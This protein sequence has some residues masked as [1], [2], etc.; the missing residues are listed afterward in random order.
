MN[1]YISSAL[2]AGITLLIFSFMAL[3]ATINFLPEY[4]S[5]FYTDVFWPSGVRAI[6]FYA[7]PFI[8]SFAL[9]WFWHRFKD[10]LSGP[11]P[12]RGLELGLIYLF[13]AIVPMM[14]MTFSSMDLNPS[15]IFSWSIY[16]FMQ[17]SIAGYVMARI[18][19]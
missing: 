19:P 4:S 16:G 10:Q 12:I 1:K 8:L 15:K 6:M 7:H 2:A 13:I 14:W 17:A 3:F 11:P 5:Y 9:A 18:N